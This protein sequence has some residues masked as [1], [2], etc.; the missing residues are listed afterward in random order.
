MKTIIGRII[1][2]LVISGILLGLATKSPLK[3]YSEPKP[4]LANEKNLPEFKATTLLDLE[5]NPTAIRIAILLP[6]AKPLML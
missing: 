6:K 4:A 1:L 5:E 2:L 3:S